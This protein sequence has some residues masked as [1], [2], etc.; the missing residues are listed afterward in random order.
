MNNFIFFKIISVQVKAFRDIVQK[1][2]NTVGG[3][4]PI[5]IKT[6]IKLSLERLYF[7]YFST[8]IMKKYITIKLNNLSTFTNR[9]SCNKAIVKDLLIS[10][11]KTQLNIFSH[12][13]T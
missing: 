3:H 9:G 11:N 7:L 2:M 4:D 12:S 6:F 5:A 10:K 1:H 8:N 13:V